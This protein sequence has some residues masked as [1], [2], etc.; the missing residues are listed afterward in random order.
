MQIANQGS[1]TGRKE[2]GEEGT[3]STLDKEGNTVS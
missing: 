3:K 2:K 1:K